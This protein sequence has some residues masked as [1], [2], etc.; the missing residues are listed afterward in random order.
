LLTVVSQCARHSI[1]KRTMRT[2][3]YMQLAGITV[4]EH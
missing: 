1:F 4:L 3:V 2:K